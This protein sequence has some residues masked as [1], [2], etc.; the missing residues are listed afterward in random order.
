MSTH[1]GNCMVPQLFVVRSDCQLQRISDD[2]MYRQQNHDRFKGATTALNK[3]ILKN[4]FQVF[5]SPRV[6]IHTV[7]GSTA[8]SVAEV[9]R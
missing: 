8:S 7:V 5:S 9:R 6:R 4:I 2:L 3:I 1:F